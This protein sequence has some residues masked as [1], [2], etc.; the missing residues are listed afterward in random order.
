MARALGITSQTLYP[1][2]LSGYTHIHTNLFPHTY[3]EESCV[4]LARPRVSLS[5]TQLAISLPIAI[6][7]RVSSRGQSS[8]SSERTRDRCVP[9]FR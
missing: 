3:R 6:S 8:K 7:T 2:I 1:G 4:G 9:R 5:H